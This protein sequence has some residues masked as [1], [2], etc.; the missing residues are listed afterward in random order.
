MTILGVPG[1]GK[2]RLV[3][4]SQHAAAGAAEPRT[5]RQ[6]RSLPYGDGASFWA[7]GEMV[8]AEAGILESDPTQTVDRKLRKAVRRIVEDPAEAG[9]IASYLGVLAGLTGGEA[10][11]ADRRGETFAAWRHFL[12][13]LA[14]ERLLVLVFEDLH[15]ADDA[16]LDF[17]DELVDRISGVPLLVVATARPELL[18]RRPGWAGGKPSALTISLLP[19]SRGYHAN[20]HRIVGAACTC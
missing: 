9:R 2:S 3:S 18:E 13:T 16:L 10:T 1:M 14:D 4:E 19:V 17:V 8:K 15:W 11:T 6:G 5:W 7:L 20:G 12:E